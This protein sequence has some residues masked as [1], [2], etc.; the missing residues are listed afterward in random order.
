MAPNKSRRSKPGQ[1]KQSVRKPKTKQA[2]A[3]PKSNTGRKSSRGTGELPPEMSH[4]IEHRP[5]FPCS[6]SLS[7]LV[8]LDWDR[9][10]ELFSHG[11]GVSKLERFGFKGRLYDVESLEPN[12]A[13]NKYIYLHP[14]K[15]YYIVPID[16]PGATSNVPYRFLL[17]RSG[18][19]TEKPG[20]HIFVVEPLAAPAPDEMLAHLHII[21]GEDDSEALTTISRT[22]GI[23]EAVLTATDA[24]PGQLLEPAPDS[25]Q[26]TTASEKE[27]ES[28][29]PVS[30]TNLTTAKMTELEPDEDLLACLDSFNAAIGYRPAFAQ[31]LIP[32]RDCL[33]S[34]VRRKYQWE[35]IPIEPQITP[36]EAEKGHAGVGLASISS[37]PDGAIVAVVRNGYTRNGLVK[38]DAQVIVNRVSSYVTQLNKLA[39][40]GRTQTYLEIVAQQGMI[41]DEMIRDASHQ[42]GVIDV[43]YSLL[44]IFTAA[45]PARLRALAEQLS[46]GTATSRLIRENLGRTPPLQLRYLRRTPEMYVALR[47]AAEPLGT[48]RHMLIAEATQ[49]RETN[50]YLQNNRSWLND[51]LRQLRPD[52]LTAADYTAFMNDITQR[53]EQLAFTPEFVTNTSI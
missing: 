13:G 38:R 15:H 53:L 18:N 33:L 45:S 49:R 23:V 6:L 44:T 16:E 31:D 17:V 7:N 9:R 42:V 5:D 43:I 3:R 37:A 28:V 26:P 11:P 52:G 51:L 25:T 35:I 22:A 4:P 24:Q 46:A 30:P 40:L 1:A 14:E 32:L 41:L 8:R 12:S 47:G 29:S 20:P 10:Q 21:G 34:Y 2:Q 50:Y 48:L 36:Y 39:P 27:A 19:N